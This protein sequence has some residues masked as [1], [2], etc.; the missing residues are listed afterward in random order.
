MIR[1]ID[2]TLTTP[3][4]RNLLRKSG[5]AD[6]FRVQYGS[7]SPITPANPANPTLVELLYGTKYSLEKNLTDRMLF[8]YSVTFDQIQNKLDLRHSLELSYRWQKNTFLKGV[9]DL[10]ANNPDRQYDRRIMV[11]QQWRFGLP[12]KKK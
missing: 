6:S 5:I 11:E 1:L 3:L 9:F 7:E 12:G 10:N 2:S 8:G 4:A